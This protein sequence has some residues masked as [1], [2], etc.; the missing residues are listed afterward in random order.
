MKQIYQTK[1]T[2]LELLHNK[3]G[4]FGYELGIG[5]YD[6]KLVLSFSEQELRGICNFI[7][8]FLEQEKDDS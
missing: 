4:D 3:V 2:T 1:S 5:L 6:R 7:S 8:K